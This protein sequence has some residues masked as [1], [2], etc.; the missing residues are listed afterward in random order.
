M[1]NADEVSLF[2]ARARV[3]VPSPGKQAR[4]HRCLRGGDTLFASGETQTRELDAAVRLQ[5]SKCVVTKQE[6]PP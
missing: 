1:A 4:R 2:V 5:Y 6:T 3:L